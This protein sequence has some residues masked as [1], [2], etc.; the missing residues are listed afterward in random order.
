MRE[1]LRGQREIITRA[2]LTVFPITPAIRVWT[3]HD[4]PTCVAA[5][6]EP[7]L[8]PRERTYTRL[9]QLESD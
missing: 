6:C 7:T 3:D 9:N 4:R 1:A 5:S 8:E 2:L